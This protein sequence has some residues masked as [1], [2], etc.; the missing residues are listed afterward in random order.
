[1]RGFP[2]LFSLSF[3]CPLQGDYVGRPGGVG[4]CVCRL[5]PCRMLGG[6]PYRFSVGTSSVRLRGRP[7]CEVALPRLGVPH[8]LPVRLEKSL[9]RPAR[10]RLPFVGCHCVMRVGFAVVGPNSTPLCSAQKYTASLLFCESSKRARQGERS[11][12]SAQFGLWPKL[13]QKSSDI[14]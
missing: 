2:T 10:N 1:M 7:P 11:Q 3:Q 14:M 9:N 13:L 5:G 4:H 12:R 8:Y 6:G